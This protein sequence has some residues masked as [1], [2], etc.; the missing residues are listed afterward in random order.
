MGHCQRCKVVRPVEN[1]KNS[2]FEKKC[3]CNQ[4][5]QFHLMLT[6]T[7]FDQDKFE[8]KIY[9]KNMEVLKCL[10]LYIPAL[11]PENL[12][13]EISNKTQELNN[14]IAE[15]GIAKFYGRIARSI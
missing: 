9:I 15:F 2:D 8:T 10:G 3:K 7:V 13:S 12:E 5:L 6:V 4:N 11:K 1:F 14:K